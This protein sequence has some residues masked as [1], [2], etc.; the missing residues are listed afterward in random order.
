MAMSFLEV[1]AFLEF[2]S[3]ERTLNNVMDKEEG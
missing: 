3:V 2:V 1:L